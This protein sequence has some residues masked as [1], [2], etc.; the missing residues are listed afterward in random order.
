MRGPPALCSPGVLDPC[1]LVAAEVGAAGP[2]FTS[3]RITITRP[4]ARGTISQIRPEVPSWAHSVE[5]R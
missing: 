4:T 3:D 2:Y 1:D 5:V